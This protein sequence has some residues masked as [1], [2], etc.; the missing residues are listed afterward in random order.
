M[1]SSCLPF[2]IPLPIS[3]VEESADRQVPIECDEV[4]LRPV[5]SGSNSIAAD[6]LQNVSPHRRVPQSPSPRQIFVA[7]QRAKLG[8]MFGKVLA[9]MIFIGKPELGSFDLSMRLN[10]VSPRFRRRARPASSRE[11]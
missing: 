5:K 2:E 1:R 6:D 10:S 7:G 3:G 9:K 8:P 4:A 11:H